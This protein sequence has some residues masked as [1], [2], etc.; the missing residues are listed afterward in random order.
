MVADPV[1]FCNDLGA[2]E[3]PP[4]TPDTA[5]TEIGHHSTSVKEALRIA[6]SNNFMGLLCNS[7][8]LVSACN[9]MKCRN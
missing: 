7:R 4:Q 2:I 1:L 3:T 9:N 8:L 5:D 6:Q